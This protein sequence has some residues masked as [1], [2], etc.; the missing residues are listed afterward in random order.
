MTAPFPPTEPPGYGADL[1][2]RVGNSLALGLLIA[3]ALTASLLYFVL[4][5][6]TC[7]PLRAGLTSLSSGSASVD[8]LGQ[9]A[10]LFVMPALAC[11]GLFWIILKIQLAIMFR[12]LARKRMEAAMEQGLKIAQVQ[13]A[14][15]NEQ[16]LEN[17]KQQG[18]T[19]D[20][21]AAIRQSMEVVERKLAADTERR[22]A[23]YRQNPALLEREI[24][25]MVDHLNRGPATQP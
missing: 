22:M 1:G 12:P 7:A 6:A 10:L 3:V 16:Y 24:R 18:S 23:E 2:R 4:Y 19:E 17:M 20:E 15:S 8:K 13:T 11:F 25:G 9:V 14:A 21:I 5:S